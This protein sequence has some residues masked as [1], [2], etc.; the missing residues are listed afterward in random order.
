MNPNLRPNN[1][2]P[3]VGARPATGFKPQPNAVPG[4][5]PKLDVVGAPGVPVTPEKPI[6]K[7]TIQSGDTLSSIARKFNMDLKELIEMNKD[8][9]TNPD[10][11]HSGWV[12]KV[13]LQPAKKTQKYTIQSSDTLSAIARKFNVPLKDIIDLNKAVIPNPDVIHSG[14]VIDIPMN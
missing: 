3:N 13:P 2:G 9:I 10:V 1:A 14:T 8:V 4:A 6:Q 12:I 11:I 5:G 7:Y